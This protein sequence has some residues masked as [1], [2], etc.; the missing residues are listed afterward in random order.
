MR[1]LLAAGDGLKLS[2]EKD[3]KPDQY[4]IRG[5]MHMGPLGDKGEIHPN[6]LTYMIGSDKEKAVFI[7]YA[8][9]TGVPLVYSTPGF[10]VLVSTT[11]PG[12][13]E[14]HNGSPQ[15]VLNGVVEK[16]TFNFGFGLAGEAKYDI[17]MQSFVESLSTSVRE[18]TVV[19]KGVTL[20][21]LNTRMEMDLPGKGAKEG[22]FAL[23][24]A[25]IY[26]AEETAKEPMFSVDFV[27]AAPGAEYFKAG[28][29]C[30]E[31]EGR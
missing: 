21:L 28:G 9:E 29:G 7:L 25:R 2:L 1:K 11:S 8:T 16:K 3:A 13:L 10:S 5:M 23:K 22:D 18:V 4:V 14:L 17:D 12:K 26:P 30:T 19:E 24:G 15:V 20:K 31:A 27:M 6:S